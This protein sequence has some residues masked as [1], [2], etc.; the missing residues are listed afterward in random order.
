M[1]LNNEG[2]TNLLCKRLNGKQRESYDL[3]EI[4]RGLCVENP[5]TPAEYLKEPDHLLNLG[6]K[7]KLNE[8]EKDKMLVR[9]IR[10]L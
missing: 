1:K 2:A 9:F 6:G 7:M 4:S 10:T 5:S 8:V 3:R